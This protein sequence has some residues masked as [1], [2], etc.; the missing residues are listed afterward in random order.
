MGLAAPQ[1]VETSQSKDWTCVPSI[2]RQ[3]HH[4]TTREVHIPSIFN[5][6]LTTILF[7]KN[8]LEIRQSFI[9]IISHVFPLYFQVVFRDTRRFFS[10]NKK[11]KHEIL[12]T[13]YSFKTF[14]FCYFIQPFYFQDL[15]IWFLNTQLNNKY[16]FSWRLRKRAF[17]P[18]ETVTVS[19][20]CRSFGLSLSRTF[21]G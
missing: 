2:S 14:F 16:S 1:H 18:S 4:W 13:V 17:V 20:I 11:T 8:P 10:E 19:F 7:P 9:S 6:L 21:S 12:K 5:H 3:T 15:L